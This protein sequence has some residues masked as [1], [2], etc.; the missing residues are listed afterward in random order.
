MPLDDIITALRQRVVQL[1]CI[2]MTLVQNADSDPISYKGKGYIRQTDDD[3]LTFKIFATETKGTNLFEQLKADLS[4]QSGRLFVDT[5]YYTLSA[6][7]RDGTIWAAESILPKFHWTVNNPDPIVVGDLYTLVVND[8]VPGA[9][10]S[11]R[12]HFFDEANIP[13]THLSKVDT[14]DGI[15]VNRD[16][17]KFSAAGCDFVIRKREQGFTVDVS[18]A[19]PL[20]EN[21]HTRI[22]E[23]LR[24]LLARSVTWR[25]LMRCDGQQRH[26]ELASGER[27]APK[28]A[29]QPPIAPDHAGFFDCGWTL[30]SKYLE[31]ILKT[32]RH[33]YWNHC[34]YHLHNAC[35]VS[36]DSFDS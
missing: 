15:T 26:V 13:Y 3:R 32:T 5:D 18:S 2:E 25:V 27:R 29:L 36:G 21:L 34:S 11:L 22:Q 17:A 1:D 35:E 30:F 7:E 33:P 23:S 9:R 20:D 6:M 16:V 28:T 4:I 31:Y 8:R 14:A 24:F 19:V 10:H 12:L